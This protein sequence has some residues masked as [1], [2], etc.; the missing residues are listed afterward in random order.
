MPFS[1]NGSPVSARLRS[2][3]AILGVVLL[4]AVTGWAH[5]N[6][7][8]DLSVRGPLLW[9]DHVYQLIAATLMAAGACLFGARILSHFRVGITDPLLRLAVSFVLGTSGVAT[10]L[11][12]V[13]G[14]GLLSP[15]ITVTILLLAVLVGAPEW[16]KGRKNV[17]A[18]GMGV[19]DTPTKVVF[20]TGLLVLGLWALAPPTDY[21]SLMYHLRIPEQYLDQ[22]RVFLPEANLHAS[23]VGLWHF[24]YLA[25]LTVIGR[26][27]PAL[28]NVISLGILSLAV[29]GFCRRNLPPQ[30]ALLVALSIWSSTILLLVAVT[31]RVDVP[32]ALFLWTA[33]V[34][35]LDSRDSPVPQRAAALAGV[36]F[37]LSFGVKYFAAPFLV[38]SAPVLMWIT[39]NRSKSQPAGLRSLAGFAAGFSL[40]SIPWLLKNVILFGAPVFPLL[41]EPRLEPWLASLYGSTAVPSSVDPAALTALGRARETFNFWDLFFDPG[42][43]TPEAEG[44][45]YFTGPILLMLPV[46]VLTVKNLRVWALALT[47]LIYTLLVTIPFPYLNLRYLIP[48]LAPLSVVAALGIWTASE[49]TVPGWSQKLVFILVLGSLMPTVTVAYHRLSQTRV[50]PLVLG[51]VSRAEFLSDPR[52]P[53]MLFYSRMFPAVN[54]EL[55]DGSRTLMLFEGR[56][57]YFD[58]EVLQ[59]NRLTNWALLAPYARDVRCLE[60]T[61]ITHILVAVSSLGYYVDRGLNPAELSWPQFQELAARC[62]EVVYQDPGYVLLELK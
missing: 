12:I 35:L 43:L 39:W 59:D 11:L 17:L 4:L 37:G 55:P 24:W 31:A 21:D 10:I 3:L 61:D 9:L 13:G 26:A 5:L 42:K 25:T 60:G 45:F 8:A 33:L 40:A 29:W 27:G 49:K 15:F 46:A 48:A 58:R 30:A 7:T 18:L 62:T 38:A 56:G 54:E 23:L 22:G 20:G 41:A 50:I 51:L 47:G 19:L 57:L 1:P 28:V 14:T 32:L 6:A 2:K 52:N 53:D 34:T 16:R 36:L 44:R